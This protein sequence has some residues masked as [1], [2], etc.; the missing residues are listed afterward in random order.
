MKIKTQK[1]G[2]LLP[3]LIL[4]LATVPMAQAFYNPS[5]GRWLNRDPIAD[6][7]GINLYSMVANNPIRYFDRFGL[8]PVPNGPNQQRNNP[9]ACTFICKNEKY[10]IVVGR[11]GQGKPYEDCC[12][13]HEESHIEDWK[14]RYGDDSCKGVPDGNIPKLD[15]GYDAFRKQSECKAH[16]KGSDCAKEYLNSCTPPTEA[17]KAAMEA[18]KKLQDDYLKN[19]NC[20]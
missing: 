18:F 10:E 6:L 2:W 8:A 9:N 4:W 16:K 7:G 3:S 15:P 1:I 19:N 14:G 11:S 5:L 13:K 12:R 20:P 17:N